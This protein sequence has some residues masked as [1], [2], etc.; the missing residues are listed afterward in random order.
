MLGSTTL[1]THKSIAAGR[2]AFR[3]H[4]PGQKE[5]RLPLNSLEVVVRFG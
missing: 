5:A 1:L 4:T 3:P 2:G